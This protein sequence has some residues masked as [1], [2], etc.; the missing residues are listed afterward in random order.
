MGRQVVL[1]CVND[2][3]NPPSYNCLSARKYTLLAD[4]IQNFG[5]ALTA[6]PL[7]IAFLFARKKIN[8]RFTYGYGRVEDLAG[9][10]V[11]LAILISAVVAG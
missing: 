3:Y 8:K 11:V 4:T 9:F 7:W 10:F 1:L 6:L 2:Y 5:D